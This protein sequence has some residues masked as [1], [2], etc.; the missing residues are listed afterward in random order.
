KPEATAEAIV[1]GWLRTGDLGMIGEGGTI[2][3]LGRR[4]EMLKVKGM[5]VFPAEIEA[6][7]GYP[8]RAAMVHRDDLAVVGD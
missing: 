6:V 4:K 2:H 5:S 1:G 7:L 3:F 8:G